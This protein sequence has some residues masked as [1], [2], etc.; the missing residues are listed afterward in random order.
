MNT[1]PKSNKVN[2]TTPA[3]YCRCNCGQTTG[4]KAIYRPGHDAVHVS[5]LLADLIQHDEFDMVETYKKEFPSD[6]LRIKF[7]RAVDN[8]LTKK[9]PKAKKADSPLEYDDTTEY[10]VGRWTYPTACRETPRKADDQ[11]GDRYDWHRNT[12]RDGS[13]EWVPAEGGEFVS[14]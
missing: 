5:V 9:A 11:P 6:A 13:G 10:K 3:G 7:Q 1:T 12:K 14:K 4:P 8:F 2:N